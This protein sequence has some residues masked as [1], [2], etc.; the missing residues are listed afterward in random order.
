MVNTV[1]APEP[2]LFLYAIGQR[3]RIT[4][5]DLEGEVIERSDR[6]ANQTDYKVVYWCE[7]KRNVEWLIPSELEP[8]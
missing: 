8:A 2:F 5:L 4:P 1:T 6:G 3:V 7:S